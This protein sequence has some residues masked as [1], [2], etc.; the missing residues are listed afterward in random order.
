LFA[1]YFQQKAKDFFEEGKLELAETGA[2]SA[3]R[4]DPTFAGRY[5]NLGK[6]EAAKEDVKKAEAMYRAAIILYRPV[7]SQ[8]AADAKNN[9]AFLL[10]GQPDGGQEAVS[11]V[12]EAI[13]VRGERASYLD[14]LGRA[15]DAVDDKPC[16]R[17][18]YSKLLKIQSP[19]V[20]AA[21][22]DHARERVSSLGS[23]EPE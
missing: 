18:A 9:L 6:I 7:E 16:S 17:K 12:R 11:L 22:R 3:I 10:V 15:C 14:T 20:P 8:L 5:Y 23:I 4:V 19:D 13:A 1:I 21:V 2:V